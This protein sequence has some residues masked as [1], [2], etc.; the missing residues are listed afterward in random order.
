MAT[1][2]DLDGKA[3]LSGDITLVL[4][5]AWTADITVD[6]DP[7]AVGAFLKFRVHNKSWMGTTTQCSGPFGRT[8]ARLIAGAGRFGNVV[9]ARDY[10]NTSLDAVISDLLTD[11]GESA[12]DLS[13]L[14]NTP[15]AHWSRAGEPASRCLRRLMRV[16]PAGMF[17][18]FD[19]D[20]KLSAMQPTWASVASYELHDI[21]EVWPSD[22]ALVAY[23]VE[24]VDFFPGQAITV[25]GVL[26]KIEAVQ[27]TL[28]EKTRA[29]IWFRE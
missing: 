12:G 4:G 25:A 16:A 27:Y 7:P 22:N 24:S 14:A 13:L 11:S 1:A 8:N 26:K 6:G 5:G 10:Q 2:A 17:T 23:V 29:I 19:G 15:L 21:A 3:I 28:G 9:E 20:G 18:Y